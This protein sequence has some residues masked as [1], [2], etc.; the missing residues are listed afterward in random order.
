VRKIFETRGCFEKSNF[1][2]LYLLQLRLF[3]PH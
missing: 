3:F 1:F 2:S